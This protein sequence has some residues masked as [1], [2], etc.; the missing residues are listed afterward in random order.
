M[1]VALLAEVVDAWLVTVSAQQGL[2]NR[3]STPAA[4]SETEAGDPAVSV[5]GDAWTVADGSALTQVDLTQLQAKLPREAVVEQVHAQ[6]LWLSFF[7]EA[8]QVGGPSTL[9]PW[10]LACTARGA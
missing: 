3:D 4:P 9:L 5:P 7:W 10:R 2:F 6:A 8:W 1:Q